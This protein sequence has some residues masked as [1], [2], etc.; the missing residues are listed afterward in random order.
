MFRFSNNQTEGEEVTAQQGR[1]HHLCMYHVQFLC[2][3][4]RSSIISGNSTALTKHLHLPDSFEM[5]IA[6][7]ADLKKEA[8]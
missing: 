5:E 4:C 3:S 1:M 7:L 2:T 6:S 8:W